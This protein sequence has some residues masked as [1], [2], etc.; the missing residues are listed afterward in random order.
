MDIARRTLLR[1]IGTGAVV[2]A[3]PSLTNASI[4][5]AAVDVTRRR[6]GPVRLHRNENATGPS[7]AVIAAMRE[8]SSIANRYPEMEQEVLRDKLADLHGVEPSNIVLG[9]GSSEIL[10]IASAA[11]G[12][13]GKNVVVALPTLGLMAESAARAG[14][15]VIAVPLTS[16]YAHDLDAMLSKI[17]DGTGLVYVCNPNNPTGTVTRRRDLELFLRGLPDA[18]RVVIDEAYH[19]Y[20][21]GAS[22]YASFIERPTGDSRVIVTRTLSTI[23]GLAGLRI[24]YA[25]AAPQVASQL[26]SLR[27]SN[28]V[29]AVAACAAIIALD[30][31][32][33]VRTSAQRNADVRQEFFNQANARML[34]TIDSHTN[35][36]MLNTDRNA[37]EIIEHF[38]KNDVLV[39]GPF[40]SFPKYIRVS[41]GT[42][43]EMRAFW[44]AWDL[45]PMHHMSM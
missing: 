19:H 36:V 4:T 2:A 39:S 8:A 29:N 32:D 30:D 11:F 35:F 43:D 16:G 21:G 25:V 6:V 45:S 10:R 34:R 7:P 23:H 12:G 38:S 3:M 5:A 18:T 1:Q 14:A 15:E 20:A 31:V 24:G 27:L 40:P 42:P 33:H 13:P 22:E 28:G 17:N 41:L 9:C 26:A 37:V 44:R